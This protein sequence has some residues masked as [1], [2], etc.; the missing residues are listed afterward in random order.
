MEG[1]GGGEITRKPGGKS[2]LWGRRAR[3][4]RAE[5]WVKGRGHWEGG[6]KKGWVGGG[7][8]GKGSE[9]GRE[10]KEGGSELW[11]MLPLSLPPL[12]ST[13]PT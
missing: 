12:V 6:G 8:Q 4:G 7:R 10:T 5:K 9:E 2:R 1:G 13:V 3:G 11:P